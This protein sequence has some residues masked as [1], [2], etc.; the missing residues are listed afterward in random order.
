M[1][2]VILIFF[3]LIIAGCKHHDQ[4]NDQ[5]KVNNSTTVRIKYL[6]SLSFLQVEDTSSIP[7]ETKNESL[8]GEIS[9]IIFNGDSIYI[10]DARY[11]KKIFC[12]SDKGKFLFSFG[13]VGEGANEYTKPTDFIIQNDTIILVDNEAFNMLTYHLN[14]E[15]IDKVRIN[16]AIY[17]LEHGPSQTIVTYIPTDFILGEDQETYSTNTIQVVD[18]E[19]SKEIRGWLPYEE[20][21]DDASPGNLLSNSENKTRYIHPIYGYIFTINEDLEATKDFILDYGKYSWPISWDQFTRDQEETERL[22]FEGGIMTMAHNIL[23][24]DRFIYLNA[25]T[26]ETEHRPLKLDGTA[27]KWL[28]VI[29]KLKGEAFAAPSLNIDNIPVSYQ[30]PIAK[31]GNYL[32]SLITHEDDSRDLKNP[33]LFIYKFRRTDHGR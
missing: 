14:G 10:L 2:K 4:Y 24:D 17:E 16:R 30:F 23:E 19:M 18:R 13:Q 28:V 9:K 20:I 26:Q 25:L 1:K 15:F 33:K 21:F 22:F 12:F 32:V 7:L 5:V 6:E 3:I 31:K 27:L 8:I 11:S 29:D